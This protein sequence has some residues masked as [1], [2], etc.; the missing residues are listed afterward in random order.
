V[1]SAFKW[2]GKWKKVADDDQHVLKSVEPDLDAAATHQ[3]RKNIKEDKK[4]AKPERDRLLAVV[5]A[6][7]KG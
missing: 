2:S 6:A 4:L 5:Q 7:S 1:T 3:A